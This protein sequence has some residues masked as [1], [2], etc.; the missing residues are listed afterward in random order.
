MKRDLTVVFNQKHQNAIL[1]HMHANILWIWIMNLKTSVAD[2]DPPGSGIRNRFFFRIPNPHFLKLNDKSSTIRCK[3]GKFFLNQF[4]S[5]I[6]FN[7]V[8]FC[9]YKKRYRKDNK[10][11]FIALFLDVFGSKIRDPGW[12]KIRIRNTL[13]IRNPAERN[14]EIIQY[15]NPG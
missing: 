4:L 1:V 11:F 6:N 5:N 7:F 2:P 12:T 9:G 3:L 10:F 14:Q 15:T 8:I 13:R